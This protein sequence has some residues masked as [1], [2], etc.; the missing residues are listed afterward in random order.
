MREG[1]REDKDVKRAGY[2][3]GEGDRGNGG[4]GRAGWGGEEWGNG[5]SDGK[6]RKER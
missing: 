4:L 5:R 1:R 6:V 2:K 3:T